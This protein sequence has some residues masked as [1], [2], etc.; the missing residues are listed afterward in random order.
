MLAEQIPISFWML[1]YAGIGSGIDYLRTKTMDRYVLCFF[2]LI[3][4]ASGAVFRFIGLRFGDCYGFIASFVLTVIIMLISKN[5]IKEH[6]IS[7]KREPLSSVKE[8]DRLWY[9]EFKKEVDLEVSNI[10]AEKVAKKKEAQ[11]Q[12]QRKEYRE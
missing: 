3:G 4:L 9:E 10:Q 11:K 8:E 2:S 5:F 7:L 6:I 1:I 12:K